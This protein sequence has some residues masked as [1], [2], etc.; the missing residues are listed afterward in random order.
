MFGIS[1]FQKAG[2]SLGLPLKQTWMLFFVFASAG[3]FMPGSAKAGCDWL[4]HDGWYTRIQQSLNDNASTG[5]WRQSNISTQLEY[6]EGVL[7]FRIYPPAVPCSGPQC[8]KGKAGSNQFPASA[9]V[10]R[11]SLAQADIDPNATVG[12]FPTMEWLRNQNDW[13]ISP[14]IEP[15]LPPPRNV[16]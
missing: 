9:Q 12:Q 10:V 14:T 6:V 11:V 4:H 2:L 8:G 1:N 5:G 3:L 13:F 15:S 7:K 16:Q